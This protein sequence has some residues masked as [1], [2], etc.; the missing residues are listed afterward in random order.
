MD[1]TPFLPPA[2]FQST[3]MSDQL[4]H[5]DGDSACHSIDETLRSSS[6]ERKPPDHGYNFEYVDYSL[7]WPARP[8]VDPIKQEVQNKV[9]KFR[10]DLKE[11]RIRRN[12]LLQQAV[13]MRI[14][15]PPPDLI[16]RLKTIE[17]STVLSTLLNCLA[18]SNFDLGMRAANKALELAQN[19]EDKKL[20]AR[21][22]YWMGRIEFQRGKIPAAHAHFKYAMPCIEDDDC[23]EGD[24]VEFWFNTTRPGMGEG[25]RNRAVHNH[26]RR[27]IDQYSASKLPV[28]SHSTLSEKRRY[29]EPCEYVFRPR[30][31]QTS[32]EQHKSA[33]KNSKQNP[34]L[35][36]WTIPDVHNE[37]YETPF[38]LRRRFSGSAKTERLSYQSHPPLPRDSKFTFR[39]Y[40][41]GLSP[42][43]RP[44]KIFRP[45]PLEIIHTRESWESLHQ[46]AM[47]KLITMT[48]L[49]NEMEL[50]D[51]MVH[52][53][54]KDVR[55][56]Y[57]ESK[58][59]Q[60]EQIEE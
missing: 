40:P 27:V 21:C 16:I 15:S 11:I 2:H 49:A 23:A 45:H 57:L 17:I 30:P 48:W 44:T 47:G 52:K 7:E 41:K 28:T 51:K 18:T 4:D 26:S 3:R 59:R 60:Q 36:P 55:R 19:L 50:Y 34:P 14:P 46:R 58:F 12:E 54:L 9:K 20:I 13:S 43:Y 5:P 38:Y 37:P 33:T 29:Q 42:R 39:C 31:R 24:F 6:G 35:V 8:H 25:Y 1:Q 53:R 32:Q 10:D 22:Y 56:K